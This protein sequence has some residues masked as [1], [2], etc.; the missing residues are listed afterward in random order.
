MQSIFPMILRELP[1]AR[2][3]IVGA[4]PPQDL[5]ETATDGMTVTGWVDDPT[6]YLAAAAVVLV[7]L[8]QGGG[9]RVKML[10]ACAAGKAII[11][12]PMAVEGLSLKD[13]EEVV[14]AETDE[15]FAARAVALMTH[16]EARTRLELASRH[17]WKDAHDVG[18]WLAQ[19]AQV[20]ESLGKAG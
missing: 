3:T 14:I 19:Y 7:P 10:E 9:L 2:L 17:W 1:D 8:R 13:G 18:R 12:S 6:T 20:Y 15:E 11:A 16:H 5:V 4:N